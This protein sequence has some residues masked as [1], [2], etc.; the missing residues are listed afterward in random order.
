MGDDQADRRHNHED[1]GARWVGGG[2][3]KRCSNCL[4]RKQRVGRVGPP[5]GTDKERPHQASHQLRHRASSVQPSQLLLRCLA[6]IEQGH[7][8]TL[9]GVGKCVW[10]VGGTYPGRERG[11]KW[12]DGHPRAPTL[13]HKA[14]LFNRRHRTLQGQVCGG[15]GGGTHCVPS[16]S[17]HEPWYPD[18]NYSSTCDL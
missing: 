10:G 2:G 18:R 16:A 5:C 6:D 7:D 9:G 8:D 15:R 3:V 12:G 11:A 13:H 14:Q 4:S 17:Q 1:L